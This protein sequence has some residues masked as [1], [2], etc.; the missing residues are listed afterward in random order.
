MNFFNFDVDGQVVD[1]V[2]DHNADLEFDEIIKKLMLD[3]SSFSGMDYET[4]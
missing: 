2:K 3:L 1:Q 4:W